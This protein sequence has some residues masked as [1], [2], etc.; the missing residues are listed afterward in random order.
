VI[1]DG[2]NGAVTYARTKIL[3]TIASKYDC[4]IYFYWND[5][6]VPWFDSW[7]LWIVLA[8]YVYSVFIE[9]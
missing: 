9:K 4:D 6:T 2:I 8:I 7:F 5:V 1:R 3:S